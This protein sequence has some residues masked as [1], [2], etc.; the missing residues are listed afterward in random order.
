MKYRGF[1]IQTDRMQGYSLID[2]ND[3]W[4]CSMV[5]IDKL[6]EIVDGIIKTD[7]D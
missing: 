4:A 1:T 7:K 6:K 3:Q 2:R 5:S